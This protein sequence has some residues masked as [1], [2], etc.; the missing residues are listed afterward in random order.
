MPKIHQ[1]HAE[2]VLPTTLEEAWSFFS[3]ASNLDAITPPELGFETLSGAGEKMSAGQI[4]VHRIKIL[5]FIR[6]GWVTEITHVDPGR[7]FVDE[8]RFG[9]YKF[10]HH[11]HAFEPDVAGGGVRMKDT[12]HYALGFWAAGAI[13]HR[14]FVRRQ[15]ENIFAHRRE[16]L[17]RHFAGP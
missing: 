1:L 6:V 8:Q 3:D 11:R 5:P 16:V 9:P 4:I 2:Q 10:W 14:L 7:M 17:A 13:A 15:L 12:I